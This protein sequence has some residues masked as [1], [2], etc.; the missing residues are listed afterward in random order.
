MYDLLLCTW[1]GVWVGWL[2]LEAGVG[3]REAGRAEDAGAGVVR[4]KRPAEVGSWQGPGARV[5]EAEPAAVL[6]A[7]PGPVG[8]EVLDG[9]HTGRLVL[10]LHLDLGPG[11]GAGHGG[12]EEDVDT[13]HD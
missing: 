2:C 7:W 12:A 1:S 8:V 10:G 4:T 11:E 6:A 13:E 5:V 9:V 3:G